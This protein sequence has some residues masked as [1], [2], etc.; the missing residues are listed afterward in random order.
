MSRIL[1]PSAWSIGIIIFVGLLLGWTARLGPPG[2]VQVPVSALLVFLIGQATPGYAG[3]RIVDTLIGAGV[4][5]IA[6]LLSPPRLRPAPS[7]RRRWHHCTVDRRSCGRSAPASRRPGPPGKRTH[8]AGRDRADRPIA[9]ARGEQEGFRLSTRWNARAR[10]ERAALGQA[11]EA[12][13]SGERI[14]VYIRSMTRALADGSGHA[15]PMPTLGAMLASTASATQAY[16]AW[17]A[18]AGHPSRPPGLFRWLRRSTPQTAPS[19]PRW[20]GS[21][22]GGAVTLNQWLTLYLRVRWP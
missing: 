2:V 21:R 13:R 6:V 15:R 11:E 14:A 22:S 16:A 9:T 8:G 4:A 7:C 12:I 19:A 17:L 20:A 5:A 3:E 1:A 10:G 18:S